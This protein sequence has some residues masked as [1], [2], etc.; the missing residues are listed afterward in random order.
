MEEDSKL[1]DSLEATRAKWE[2][3]YNGPKHFLIQA[4]GM[5]LLEILW[6]GKPTLQIEVRTNAWE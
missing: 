4:H 3:E 6:N 1:A 5:K 2:A